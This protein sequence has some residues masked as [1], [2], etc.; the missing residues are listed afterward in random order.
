L[1][2]DIDIVGATQVQ[3]KLSSDKPVAHV[4]VRLNAVWPDGAVSRL[5][6]GVLNLCHRDSHEHP[7]PLEPGKTYTVRM[8][9]D[10]V[11]VKVRKG[12]RLRIS[13]STSYWPL[14]W[15]AP[16]APTLTLHLGTSF[17]DLPLRKIR[18]EEKPPTFAPPQAAAPVKQDVVRP[19]SNRREL[20]INQATGEQTLSIVDDFGASTI[21]EHGLT[22]GA[23][24]RET[25]RIH[26]D[27]PLSARQECHWTEERARGDWKVRTETHSA[28]R[29]SK[30]H[31]HVTGRLEAYE[32]EQLI[33][34]RDWDKKIKRKLL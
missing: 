29:A 28:M 27:D 8:Q 25:Y 9:L 33:F 3:L 10:D 16:D 30:T 32:G 11:A 21:T 17:V 13:I 5:S 24:G 22:H 20:T 2:R 34:S 14:I 15:P 23:I 7:E 19:S 26:P 6:Y 18:S 31:W 4:A 12:Q 1:A